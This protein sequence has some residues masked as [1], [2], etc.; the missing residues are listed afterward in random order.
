MTEIVFLVEDAPEGG[1]TARALGE[2]IFTEAL[3]H[4]PSKILNLVNKIRTLPIAS[5]RCLEKA[6][7]LDFPRVVFHY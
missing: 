7:F 4:I 3:G 1:Y 5:S 6:F 2:S